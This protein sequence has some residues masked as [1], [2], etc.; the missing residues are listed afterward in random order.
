MLP[1]LQAMRVLPSALL[2][3]AMMVM[4]MVPIQIQTSS[5]VARILSKVSLLL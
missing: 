5:L 1:T 4:V 2:Q 3:V